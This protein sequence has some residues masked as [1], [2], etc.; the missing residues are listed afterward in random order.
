MKQLF[1]KKFLH[2]GYIPGIAQQNLFHDG[3]LSARYSNRE[4]IFNSKLFNDLLEK[5]Q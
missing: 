2:D 4:G 3:I 1:V 5:V